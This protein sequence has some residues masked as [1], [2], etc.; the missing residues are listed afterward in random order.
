MGNII[1]YARTE[2]RSFEALPFR[3]ADALVLAQLSYDEVPECV[4]R[5]DDLVAKYGTLQARAKQ[6]DIRRPIASLRMLRKPPFGGVTIARADD[7]LN[8]DKPVADH[9]VENVGLVDPQVTHDFYHAVAA[10]PRFSDVEMSAYCEQFD[11][12]A[13]TQFAAVTFRLPSG[14]LVVAF[15][16]TD[17]SLVGWK[18]DFNMAFQYPVPAQVSA[19]EY[20]KKVAS[21]WDGPILLTGHSKGGNLAVYAAMNAEDEI[22]DRVERIYSLDGP[23]FPEEVVKSFEYASVSDRIVK[24]VPDSSVVGMVFE[25]PERC[26][27]VKSDVDASCSI[28]P[29]RGRCTGVNSPRPKMWPTVRWCST[30]R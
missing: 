6:F 25:T 13:Q 17:D 30:S 5:L 19:A 20:L 23:G 4:L 18:E 27:V 24:I 16:G 22:K 21:L 2:T 29:S 14:T 15:R 7:E 26:V 9:D 28:S 12:G 11:G 3:E 10:N 8:H 1:D